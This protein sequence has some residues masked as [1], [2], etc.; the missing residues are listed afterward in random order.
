MGDGKAVARLSE[1]CLAH[2]QPNY[3]PFSAPEVLAG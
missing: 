2:G 1:C 3:G